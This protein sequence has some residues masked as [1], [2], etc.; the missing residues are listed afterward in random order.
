MYICVPHACCMP[1]RSKEGNGSPKTEFTGN[2]EYL[3]LY[4]AILTHL[5]SYV[6]W[7]NSDIIVMG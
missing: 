3:I 2:C 6:H 7:Y 5:V 4:T 1:V